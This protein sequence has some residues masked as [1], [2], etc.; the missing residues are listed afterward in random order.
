MTGWKINN[1]K[2]ATSQNIQSPQVGCSWLLWEKERNDYVE[3]Y[4]KIHLLLCLSAIWGSWVFT[5]DASLL[6][7]ILKVKC[8]LLRSRYFT[9]SLLN[10][11]C[12]QACILRE[13]AVCEKAKVRVRAFS[14]SLPLSHTHT[15]PCHSQLPHC[16]LFHPSVL[17]SLTYDVKL[18]DHTS[19]P[20]S[21]HGFTTVLWPQA[22][23]GAVSSLAGDAVATYT[24]LSTALQ[25][26]QQGY[27]RASRGFIDREAHE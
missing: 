15:W 12:F 8:C 14:H 23:Y 6:Q 1:H 2:A 7:C 13:G 26:R 24:W 16:Y 17:S 4:R 21:H 11:S 9:G 25:G 22:T 3:S 20:V 5:L 18:H 27:S 19:S 10:N